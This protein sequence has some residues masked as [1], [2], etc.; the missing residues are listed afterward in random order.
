MLE[1]M[2]ITKNTQ[3]FNPRP[4]PTGTSDAEKGVP[5][6]AGRSQLP[7]NR[8][9]NR[10]LFKDCASENLP[11]LIVAAGLGLLLIAELYW[12]AGLVCLLS[13]PLPM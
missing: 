6:D 8:K 2:Y 3:N 4:H 10:C 1:G 7:Y 13:V 5:L 9:R 11:D 12:I